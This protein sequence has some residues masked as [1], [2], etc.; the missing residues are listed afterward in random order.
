MIRPSVARFLVVCL[1]MPSLVTG[2]WA[3][4]WPAAFYGDF[5]G[6]GRE[7]VSAD[8][9]F[10]EHM[11]RDFGAAT[12]AVAVVGLVALWRPT[13]ELLIALALGHLALGCVHL[14][15]HLRTHHI[16]DP[17]DATLGVGFIVAGI[18]LA[19]LLRW[20]APRISA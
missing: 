13:R 2:A 7:W 12:V 18:V 20:V 3:A 5:P 4:F 15:Y 6:G 16:L 17:I 1:T 10:N 8:G 9:P 19:G 14:T 11:T